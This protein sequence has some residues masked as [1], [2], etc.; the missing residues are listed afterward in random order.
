MANIQVAT[1]T[2]VVTVAQID[3]QKSSNEES[4][5]ETVAIFNPKKTI[6]D[7]NDFNSISICDDV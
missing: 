1:T 7:R 2:T 5:T 6:H 3:S 4:I